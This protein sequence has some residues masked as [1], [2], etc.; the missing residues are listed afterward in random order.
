LFRSHYG[1]DAFY[2]LPGAQGAHEKGGVEGDVG[3]FRRQRLVPVPKVDS[4]D[5]LNELIAG[6]DIADEARR[7]DGRANTVGADFAAEKPLLAPLPFEG[8]DPG[9]ILTPQVDKSS[10]ISVRTIRYSVPVRLIGKRV[11]VSLRA[12]HLV[13][14]DGGVEVARHLRV[15]GTDGVQVVLDHYL[16]AL[17]RKPGALP[18]SQALATAR[19]AGLFTPTHEAFWDGA[20]RALGDRDG[21]MALIGVLLLHR[22][23]PAADVIAGMAAATSVA[24]FNP[25]VVAVEARLAA[26]GGAAET[27]N[28]VSLTARRLPADQRPAPSAQAYDAL[29]PHATTRKENLA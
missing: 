8:F 10:L 2:C 16:E 25:D 1:F 23:M 15:P 19:A 20:R 28:V 4:L 5:E 24:A 6:W 13:V 18:G 22:A 27:V 9:I 14:F 26:A 11:R 21:T 12:S 3:R 29:L 7:I 17:A